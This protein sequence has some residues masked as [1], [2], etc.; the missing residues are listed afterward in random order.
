MLGDSRNS[1]DHKDK[2]VDMERNNTEGDN[3]DTVGARILTE[4]QADS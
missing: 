3:K 2:E 1:K 4:L